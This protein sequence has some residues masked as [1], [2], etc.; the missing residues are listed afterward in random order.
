MCTYY[1]YRYIQKYNTRLQVIPIRHD[2]VAQNRPKVEGREYL[3]TLYIIYYNDVSPHHRMDKCL[4]YLWSCGVQP[5]LVPITCIIIHQLYPGVLT[6]ISDIYTIYILISIHHINK[7]LSYVIRL[8]VSIF[9]CDFCTGSKMYCKQLSVTEII[10]C[11]RRLYAVY[12]FSERENKL[13]ALS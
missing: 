9:Y 2:S 4:N 3:L 1:V 7:L 13:S 12:V 8:F 5:V 6:Y 11:F 10:L